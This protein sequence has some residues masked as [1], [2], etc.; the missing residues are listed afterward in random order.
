MAVTKINAKQIDAFSGSAA[1][2][3]EVQKATTD[4]NDNDVTAIGNLTASAALIS[5]DMVI[6]GNL[7]VAGD[8]LIA[9]VSI[10]EVEDL[11]IR[12]AKN[13]ANSAQAD[14][15]GLQVGLSG[16]YE[17]S[18]LWSHADARWNVSA[19]LSASIIH[20][21]LSGEAGQLAAHDT[22]DLAEG[23]TNLYYQDERV[24]DRVSALIVGG[25]AVSST[26]D[27][28]AGTLTL[29]AQVDDVGIEIA[30]DALQL[31]ADGVKDTHIDF[32]TGAGQ[33][34]TAD[35]PED[36]NL[37]YLDSRARAAISMEAD[38]FLGYDS[39]TGAFSMDETLFSSSARGLVS[40]TDA[41]GDGSLAYNS[42]TG[43][44]TYT[45]PSAAEV[46]AHL[47]VSDTNSIDLSYAGGAFSGDVRLSGSSLVVD[48]SGL[49]VKRSGSSILED[50][51][52][53][54]VNSAFV[55]GLISETSDFLAYDSGTGVISTVNA[56]YSGSIADVIGGHAGATTAVRS[57][58]SATDFITYDSA[59]GAIGVNSG[60][61][62]GAI[63]VS[64]GVDAT[65]GEFLRYDGVNGEF[66]V[67]NGDFTGSVADAIG[68][69]PAAVRGHF[70]VTDT[71]SV[72][73]SYNSGTGAFSADLLLSG[74]SMEVSP[75]GL[76]L[77]L[78][79]SQQSFEAHESGL[80]LK[81]TVA[82]T[83]LSL[84]ADGI[85]SVDAAGAGDAVIDVSADSFQFIDANDGNSTKKESI[86]DFVALMTGDGLS[87]TG[88]VISIDAVEEVK[89]Q[90]DFTGLNCSITN[91]PVPAAS[92][93][94]FLNGMLLAAGATKDYTISGTTITLRD[95][96]L[97]L[98]ADDTVIIRYTK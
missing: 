48:A 44:I 66:S 73:M 78:S 16:T 81:S 86:A 19:P 72:D 3:L 37:Y 21:P 65:A 53:L 4:F 85:L 28:A 45:G 20:G 42:S 14:G 5:N 93:A 98:D 90:G 59:T 23:S 47:S 35:L 55:R 95:A 60:E 6:N 50:G 29:A 87:A 34:S 32:G 91:A 36:G 69:T 74:S 54:S 75:N 97:A 84:S 83:G 1:T 49:A 17:Q 22:D 56:A 25:D 88:G 27:D 41:G 94:V 18:I 62:S 40:V 46:R 77:K 33:V 31:K 43:V 30:S 2:R 63:R 80:K 67:H 24:D 58:F 9:N 39:S 11:S 10:L 38:R 61:V 8:Q 64:V 71:N 92:L 7:T 13:A 15:A 76:R 89:L 12:A 79:A 51:G 70:S 96:D 57:K 52:G 82:G 68:G 26:Y